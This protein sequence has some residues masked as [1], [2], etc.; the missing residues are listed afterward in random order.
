MT[1][2]I[3]RLAVRQ[4]RSHP[5]QLGLAIVGI[6]LGVAVAVSIDLANG[7]ALRAF[8]LA[9][10]AVSGRATHQIVGG[11]SGLPDDLYRRLRVDVG[12]RRAAPIVEGDVALFAE[13]AGA[14]GTSGVGYEMAIG[15]AG[16]SLH[17]LGI[18]P[19]VDS[20]FRPYLGSD[21]R[22]E[23]RA[24]DA[25]S[26]VAD[27]VGRPGTAL[28]AAGTARELGLAVGSALAI[29]VS[30]HRRTLT[31]IGLL[32]PADPASARALDGLLVSDI[33]T[34]QETLGAIGRLSRID[35]IVGDDAAGR[36]LLAR[37]APALPAGADLV[38]AGT[39]AGATSRMILAFQWNLSALSLLA[40]VVGMFLIYQTMTVSVV[41][42]RPLIGSLRALGV[43]R[44]E[45]F[46]LVMSE[47]LVIGIVGTVLGLALGFAMAQGLLRLVTRTINDLY[48]VVSVREVALDPVTLAKSVL[49]GIGATAV[50]ALPPA[51]EATAAPPRVVMTRA[52]LESNARRRARR[53]GWLG[54][55]V[56]AVGALVLAVPGGI[57][58]GFAGLFVVMVGCA[59]VTPAAALGLLRPL[60]HVA[61]ALFGLLG[62][63]ATRSI[64]AALS[65]T[66]VAMAAL[67]IAV[68]A[69]IGVGVMIA[70]FRE[71]VTAWLEGTLRADIYIAAPSLANS[72]QDAT[73]DP[74]LVT[75]LA[76]TPG[77]ARAS[78][79]R[80]VLVRSARGPV[81]LVALDVDPSRPPRWRFRSGGDAGVWDGDAVLVS[82]PYAN[83]H[84]VRGVVR[85]STDHGERDFRVAG[86]F[87]D[88]GSSAGVVIMSRRTYEAAWNDRK[89]SGLA[90]EAAPGVDVSALVT[91]VRERAAGGPR[92]VI[93]SNRALR[94]ASLEIFDRTFAIT[95]V[96]RT[97]SLVVAFVGMLA[98]LMA[99]SL[100]RAREI[101]VLRALG[102][103]PRQVW[104][105]VTAQTG[106]IGLLAG[107][108]AVPSGL[109]LAAVLVFVI[110][111]RSFGWTMSID[112]SPA[113]LLQGVA[114]SLLA[115][116]LAGL[117]PAWRMASAPPA[118]AL[119]DE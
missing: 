27:L 39:Q 109:L 67:M 36:A 75:R 33:A 35:L 5:W 4:L 61:G 62:R 25:L 38:A 2:Q 31:I 23:S 100:E 111:R 40:L 116:L 32:Q 80:G 7:S 76:G 6:A 117:Y 69:A 17:L 82:E 18:D 103:T 20:D 16:R 48:F 49:L 66:S 88:Y 65:R 52:S 107:V 12:V 105:L 70:S 46:A 14:A 50:A 110:N 42:R 115:A 112:P 57:A 3:A 41:Q 51:L 71:A 11:P 92:L 58:V 37:I 19:F 93:R 43:T 113:I 15:R 10:E 89:I 98:A 44:T 9:T 108:L 30:G 77:V 114:L 79:S 78:T 59:L 56:L 73:L 91:A 119:R 81:Q 53:A 94:E 99:L 28:I 26:R 97:L 60:H 86:V 54:V 96:L 22:R 63:L 8:G 90:L 45:I 72:R 95:G 102:L 118:E 13:P 1:R 68:A 21:E 24:R 104:G 83:R 101:G 64:V 55:V 106:I 84:D 47:A 87:Y 34:A 29:E 85:L 74:E